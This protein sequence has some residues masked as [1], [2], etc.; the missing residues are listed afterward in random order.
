MIPVAD[1]FAN[2]KDASTPFSV[3]YAAG[4]IPCRICHGNVKHTLASSTRRRRSRR[5]SLP[6]HPARHSAPR[7]RRAPPRRGPTRRCGCRTTRCWS[8]SRRASERRCILT[9]LCRA[10]RSRRCSRRTGPPSRQRPPCPC[11][12]GRSPSPGCR[13]A[14]PAATQVP[15][16]LPFLIAPLRMA[17]MSKACPWRCLARLRAV[18]RRPGG[19]ARG[20]RC[21]SKPGRAHRAR[22]PQDKDVIVAGLSAIRSLAEAVGPLLLDYVAP[23]L[24]QVGKFLL[25]Q[26]PV[27]PHRGCP[28]GAFEPPAR[29]SSP[30]PA[31]QVLRDEAR[32]TL[33]TL[34]ECLGPHALPL[35]RAKVPSFSRG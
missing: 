18:A 13:P 1:P 17:L 35:I 28:A 15:P 26:I 29:P 33:G 27:P 8:C 5:S 9:T 22:V 31:A 2:A 4:N 23:L 30:G 14:G 20:R 19:S 24:V 32:E 25:G 16:L 7:A 3:A 11:C 12:P 34:D 6:R 10:K 21:L